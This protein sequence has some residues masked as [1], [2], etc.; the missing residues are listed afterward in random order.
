[1]NAVYIVCHYTLKLIEEKS[2]RDFPAIS[3]AATYQ[4]VCMRENLSN[5]CVYIFEL[6]GR[7][8][9]L[10][11]AQNKNIAHSRVFSLVPSLCS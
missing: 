3:Y 10:A 4:I 1:M 9:H 2:V 7:Q 8:L 11:H 6:P 5:T